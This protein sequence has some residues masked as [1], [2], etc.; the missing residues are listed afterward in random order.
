[1]CRKQKKTEQNLKK[2]LKESYFIKIEQ[3]LI[4]KKKKKKKMF[5]LFKVKDE[6]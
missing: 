2:K 3:N 5:E 1:M 4:S 6:V